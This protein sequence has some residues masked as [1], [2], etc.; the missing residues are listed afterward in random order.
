M[1]AIFDLTFCPPVGRNETYTEGQRGPL[2]AA[3]LNICFP[4]PCPEKLTT[5]RS[6]SCKK[7]VNSSCLDNK[8]KY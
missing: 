6:N 8:E 3:T 1:E 5:G 7:D 4:L 2:K